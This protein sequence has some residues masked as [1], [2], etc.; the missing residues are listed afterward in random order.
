M[1]RAQRNFDGQEHP[2]YYMR[3]IQHNTD[4][5]EAFAEAADIDCG[6]VVEAWEKRMDGKWAEMVEIEQD[7]ERAGRREGEDHKARV[8]N[9]GVVLAFPKGRWS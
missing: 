4:F 5:I 2:D 9:A 3:E 6:A 1:S 8:L 7:G